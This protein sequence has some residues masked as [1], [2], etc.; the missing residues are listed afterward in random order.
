VSAFVLGRLPVTTSKTS[1]P[2]ALT[3]PKTIGVQKF[4]RL[5]QDMAGHLADLVDEETACVVL[6]IDD[7]RVKHADALTSGR[8]GNPMKS[9]V[10]GRSKR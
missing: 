4:N 5:S 1:T 6:G 10:R 9:R 2:K 7:R 3:S 8:L